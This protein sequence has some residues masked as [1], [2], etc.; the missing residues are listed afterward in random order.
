MEEDVVGVEEPIFQVETIQELERSRD[1]FYEADRLRYEL[2]DQAAAE[3]KYRETMDATGA[4]GVFYHLAQGQIYSGHGN[5]EYALTEF[6]I[7]SEINASIDS[8]HINLGLTYRKL[9]GR[10]RSLNLTEK[11]E[12]M[13]RESIAA[14]ERAVEINPVNAGAWSA[15]AMTY[16]KMGTEHLAKA[17]GYILRA[18]EL[19][20]HSYLGIVNLATVRQRQGK[21]PEARQLAL[22]AIE[23]RPK[24]SDGYGILGARKSVSERLEEKPRDS[25]AW[26]EKGLKLQPNSSYLL[27]E[28]GKA[29]RDLHQYSQAVEYFERALM[30]EPDGDKRFGALTNRGEAYRLAGRV[31]EAEADLRQALSINPDYQFAQISMMRLCKDAGRHEDA[32]KLSESLLKRE[33]NPQN[34]KR[35]K[36]LQGL[37]FRDRSE[38]VEITKRIIET[39]A[40]VNNDEILRKAERALRLHSG[41]HDA[42]GIIGRCL[43]ARGRY[44]EARKNLDQALNLKPEAWFY[45]FTLAKVLESLAEWAGS[46][47]EYKI[48]IARAV[49]GSPYFSFAQ[50]RL[51][52]IREHLHREETRKAVAEGGAE[53][54]FLNNKTGREERHTVSLIRDF[55]YDRMNDWK[56]PIRDI[57]ELVGDEPVFIIAKTGVGKTVTVPTKVLLALCDDLARGGADLSLR[58]PQVYVVE[59]RI[60]ICTMTMAEMN[61]GYQN[62]VAYRMLHDEG[63]RAYVQKNGI[64]DLASKDP[65][66]TGTIVKL[67][68]EYV[69]TGR[70]PYDPRHFNLYGCIT[71]ATGKINGDAPILF[72]TTGIME[73]LTF[74]GTELD[75]KYNRII[76]D[77]AHV[78]IE[79]NPAIELG[80]ALAR[81][82]GVKID[83]MSATVDPATLSKDLGVKIVY[84]GK[85]RYPIHLSNLKTSVEESILDLVENFLL[86]P[87]E[88]RFPRPESFSDAAA[89][90]KVERVRLHLLS[91]DD[92]E[93][94]GRAYPGLSNRPQGML[95]IVNSHQSENS[96]THRIA[97]LINRAGFN[98]GMTRVHTMRLASQVVRDPSQKLAF[99]RLIESI[100]EKN[101]RY[102]IVATNVVEMGLTFSSIDYVV[103][104]DSEFETVFEDGGQMV[105]KVELGVNALYQRVGRAGR[106]RPGMAFIAR[107]FGASYTALDDEILAAG[108]K[109]A[110]IRYP[111][112]KGSFLK[113]AL[114]SFRER[115][116]EQNLRQIIGAL[117]LPSRIQDDDRL[118]AYFL[119]ERDRLKRIGIASGDS[120]TDVGRAA[121]TYIGL[122]DMDFAMLL[123][124]A[125]KRFGP[126]SNMAIVFTVMAA[127]AEFSFSDLMAN[128]YYLTNPKQLSAAEIFHEDALGVPAAEAFDLIRQYEDNPKDLY[129]ALLSRQ[130]DAQL[131]S[132]ICAYVGAGYKLAAR[133][134]RLDVYA[135][136]NANPAGGAMDDYSDALEFANE[137]STMEDDADDEDEVS[138]QVKHELDQYST[139]HTIAFERS[140]VSFSDQSELINVYRLYRHFFNNYFSLLRSGRLG[141][142]ESSEL[143]RSMEEEAT[144][145]Q[146]SVPAL[147]SLNERLN[148]LL[149]HVDVELPR[150][151]SHLPSMP[152][153]D[154]EELT[155]LRDSVIRD[156]LFEREGGDERFDLCQRF[157]MLVEAM[158]GFSPGQTSEVDRL[159][160]QLDN[161]GFSVVR[162][163]AKELWHL[164]VK[165]ARRRY[166]QHV[167]LFR[168]LEIGEYLPPISKGLEKEILSLLRVCGYHR[169]LT[170]SKTDFGFAT[171]VNDQF[172]AGLEITMQEDNNPLGTS[173][174]GKDNVTVLAKL[175]PAMI[176]KLVRGGGEGEFVKQEGKG[177]RLSHVT[178][179]G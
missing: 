150:E 105:K 43:A 170:F 166:K 159:I 115:M 160:L 173:L 142:L 81:R 165:E 24:N 89:R 40:D 8:V 21:K 45:R 164:I 93:D 18:L 33:N 152:E 70:A 106:L 54:V 118:W 82:R 88:S 123:A 95:V 31:D 177:F 97:D 125:I 26:L 56:L 23:L 92:Y 71:S 48:V 34:H 153:L 132:D 10:L 102:V 69:H 117:N 90:S 148:Q 19:D 76:I 179:L 57:I 62:Y 154:E 99:D 144:K 104:M 126:R 137:Q 116:P 41:N 67:A 49:P 94:G 158:N 32:F 101:G 2:Q 141:S 7:A 157:Y 134:K 14:L 143:R 4:Y 77:E 172:G 163:D 36:E 84:A 96:D 135:T 108:L 66:T 113:L 110:A 161:F 52:R 174:E 11:A 119:N 112:A 147:Q 136:E 68:Y 78:T 5:V 175:S 128:R 17:E 155:A 59:P 16:L 111:L 171:N 29:F 22:D 3:K 167:Q 120:L 25:I 124:T 58:F 139:E 30:A 61:E 109:E 140:V 91:R 114:Y 53:I 51:L 20:P 47:R 129:K 162:A 130:V 63:F 75:P 27:S 55:L 9:A 79:A 100:E 107:D 39:Q 12:E 44:P 50:D 28:M 156:L 176:S 168:V 146:V 42:W 87:D 169:T 145:L 131:C 74:E 149:G 38:S 35:Y 83:Y 37:F 122:D 72:V 6:E 138:P 46:E 178:L 73:S 65:K 86:D 80:I 64:E 103:T 85:Q 60:P 133:D 127:A 121:L 15:L 1:L 13:I 151:E 98:H